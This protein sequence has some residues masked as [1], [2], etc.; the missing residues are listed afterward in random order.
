[1]DTKVSYDTIYACKMGDQDALRKIL[2][3][4]EPLIVQASKQII[5]SPDG[6]KV[7]IVNQD[8]RAFIESE[9]ALRIITKYDLDRIQTE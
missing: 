4:Y 7:V 5:T 2:K 9:L 6:N 1:M 3:H 8:L